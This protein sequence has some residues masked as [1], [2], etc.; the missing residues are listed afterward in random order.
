[1]LTAPTTP[2]RFRGRR[3]KSFMHLVKKAKNG[4]FNLIEVYK[5]GEVKIFR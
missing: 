4:D 3:V 2:S 5:D 1:M